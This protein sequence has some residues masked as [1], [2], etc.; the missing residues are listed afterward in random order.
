MKLS[1]CALLPLA[2]CDA[3][4]DSGDTGAADTEVC[5]DL[6]GSGTDTGD[7]PNVLGSWA[8]T[9]GVSY[10]DDNCTVSG[11]DENTEAEWAGEAFE[12]KGTVP[13]SLYVEF[14][15]DPS[16]RYEAAI[17]ARGGLSISGTHAHDAGTIYAQFGG[18]VYT[19]NDG[20]QGIDG[21]AFL[22]LDVDADKT[23][24]CYARASWSPNKSGF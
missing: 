20:R 23:I 1:L 19:G 6:D 10:W 8:T 4:A 13:N 9:F 2:A 14:Q 24:D 12:I 16:N 17:D 5:G 18:L 11:F 22:G 21:S 3:A 7:I 15:D